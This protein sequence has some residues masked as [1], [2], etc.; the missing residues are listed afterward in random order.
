MTLLYFVIILG[1]IV[2]VH[3]LGHLIT[4]K[5]FGVYCREFAIGMGPKV[6]SWQKGETLYSLRALPIGGFVAMAGEEGVDTE[7]IPA[8]RTIKGIAP[9]KR[10]IVMLAG[11]F[12]NILLAWII[13]VGVFIYQGA[14]SLPPQPVITGVVS[15]SVA[16]TAG[17][18]ANDEIIKVAFSDG[19]SIVPKDFY[20]VITYTQLYT[21]EMIFT[22]NRNGVNLTIKVTPLFNEDEGR[23]MIGLML[24]QPVIEE[25]S[26]FG[27]ILAGTEYIGTTIGEIV[28]TLSRLVRGIGLNAISGPIGIYDVTDQQAQQGLLSLIVLTAILSVNVGI[29]NLLPIPLMDGGRVVI[30]IA[31]MIIGKPINREFEQALMTASVILVIGLALFI[32]WQDILRLLG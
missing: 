14:R 19:T 15:G 2:F 13:F 9:V 5:I 4:A 20:E 6:K 32:T 22:V 28:N 25:L 11:I 17:F 16:E 8:N 18:L 31:E 12:M 21:D 23:Y 29:F 3:E 7:D 1:I 27:A 26:F 30:T 10:I 24:P